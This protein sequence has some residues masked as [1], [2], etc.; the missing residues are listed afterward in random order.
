MA[1]GLWNIAQLKIPEQ[2]ADPDRAATSHTTAGDS[3]WALATQLGQTR[4]CSTCW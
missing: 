2:G 4:N 1:K 3:E